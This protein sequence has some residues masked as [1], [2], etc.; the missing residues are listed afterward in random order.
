MVFETPSS[1]GYLDL[2]PLPSCA[3]FTPLLPW[4]PQA[5]GLLDRFL[6]S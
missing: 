3:H 1:E 5:V 4:I 6:N 2:I